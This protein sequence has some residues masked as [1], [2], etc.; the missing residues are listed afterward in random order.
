VITTQTVN[1]QGDV[2]CVTIP[3]TT[4][5]LK[6]KLYRLGLRETPAGIWTWAGNGCTIEVRIRDG[7]TSPVVCAVWTDG[8]FTD[9]TF[10]DCAS[11]GET[12][13][14]ENALLIWLN[15]YVSGNRCTE[16]GTIGYVSYPQA[17]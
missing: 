4:Q 6:D 11:N 5:R 9:V 10:F 16:Q 17:A 7:E 1:T 2:E 14:E 13:Q 8:A 12:S 3:G 15:W